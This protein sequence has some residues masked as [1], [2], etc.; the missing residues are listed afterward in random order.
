MMSTQFK[1]A[2]KKWSLFGAKQNRVNRSNRNQELT[3]NSIMNQGLWNT[4]S[5]STFNSGTVSTHVAI[6]ETNVM[7]KEKMEKAWAHQDDWGWLRNIQILFWKSKTN[8]KSIF[9]CLA[10]TF[11]S[12]DWPS[13]SFKDST[14]LDGSWKNRQSSSNCLLRTVGGRERFPNYF[15]TSGWWLH[16]FKSDWLITA[17]MDEEEGPTHKVLKSSQELSLFR[18][19]PFWELV[20]HPRGPIPNPI[21]ACFCQF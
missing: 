7:S 6:R 3:S 12:H 14:S 17:R 15:V 4:S 18:S 19:S 20:S 11:I 9:G 21:R 5:V 13:L 8:F 16:H 2:R 10:L 1:K